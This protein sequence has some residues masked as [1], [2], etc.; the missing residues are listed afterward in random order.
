MLNAY[1]KAVC[2]SK[3]KKKYLLSKKLTWCK[4]GSGGYAAISSISSPQLAI[5]N[6]EN[7]CNYLVIFDYICNHINT[8]RQMD[9]KI[10]VRILG[11]Q[12]LPLNQVDPTAKRVITALVTL[13][14]AWVIAE[15]IPWIPYVSEYS[16]IRQLIAKISGSRYGYA[17]LEL[18]KYEIY[19]FLALR[20]VA[21]GIVLSAILFFC[22]CKKTFILTGVLTII[23]GCVSVGLIVPPI[24]NHIEPGNKPKIIIMPVL[25]CVITMIGV[26][27]LFKALWGVIQNARK[28]NELD[29]PFRYLFI[30]APV[31]AFIP[32][33]SLVWALL[34]NNKLTNFENYKHLILTVIAIAISPLLMFIPSFQIIRISSVITSVA[35]MCFYQL[36]FKAIGKPEK[37]LTLIRILIAGI[38][39]A[40]LLVIILLSSNPL[41]SYVPSYALP[42]AAKIYALP[43][44]ALVIV[45]Y[46]TDKKLLALSH[47][48]KI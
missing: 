44:I 14:L 11:N 42:Y 23:L 47:V 45:A 12:R 3:V 37:A 24:V 10:K 38:A 20:T 30:S 36:Y 46:F 22:R 25:L 18:H 19:A 6:C 15:F 39:V 34:I 31:V 5:K 17:F 43:A 7:Q 9:N 27:N 33:L 16:S 40:L 28:N 41:Y 13:M 32:V 21:V 1:R 26:Y 48:R 29:M 8:L 35:L 2:D 4:R